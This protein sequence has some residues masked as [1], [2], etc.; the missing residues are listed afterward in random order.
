M[1]YSLGNALFICTILA[2]SS[3]LSG[4]LTGGDVDEPGLTTSASPTPPAGTNGAPSISGNPPPAIVVGNQYSF[5]P[6]ASDPDGDTLTFEIQNKPDWADFDASTGTLSG[7]A[8]LGTE[9]EYA[10]ILIIVSDGTNSTS[11]PAFSIDVTQAA[12]GSV[13]L[14]WTPPT[15]NT[16]GSPLTDLAGY[17]IRYGTSSGSYPNQISIDNPGLTTYVVENLVADTYYFVAS[18]RNAE[19]AESSF[20]NE[21]Q[22]TVSPN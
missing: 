7:M 12:L 17:R 21:V 8:P 22:R 19:G 1:R 5:R 14:S 3:S 6:D 13:T 4:C 15:E 20:S 10:G 16:D 11:L 9:G 2:T 18:A